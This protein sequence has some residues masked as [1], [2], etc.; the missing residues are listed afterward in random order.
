[1]ARKFNLT[2]PVIRNW[3]KE[4]NAEYFNGELEMPD[5]FEITQST[6]VLGQ[7]RAKYIGWDYETLIRISNYYDR[8]ENGFKETLLHEMVHQWQYHHH[9]PI[10]H[11]TNFK[12]KANEINRK[13]GWDISRTTTVD[14]GVAEGIKEKKR[15]PK[16]TDSPTYI[17]K[18]TRNG[19][20]PAFA[21]IPVATYKRIAASPRA[22]NQLKTAPYYG[23]DIKVYYTNKKP[24]TCKMFKVGRTHII[25]YAIANY[26]GIIEP[27]LSAAESV[28]F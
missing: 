7:F 5:K 23:G 9:Y 22:V 10:D 25:N 8:D 20:I 6:R 2:I 16:G 18:F 17:F 14:E 4:F 12:R 11:K 27:V 26:R 21:F 15:K 28:A 13:G 3:W 24:A 19:N 1:M